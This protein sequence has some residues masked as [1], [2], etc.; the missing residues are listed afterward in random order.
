MQ[1]YEQ[2]HGIRL[3]DYLDLHA[4]LAPNAA[5]LID[6]TREFW[7][8][9][10]VVSGDYWIVDSENHGAP[11]A[12]RLIPRLRE[13]V[14]QYYP[15]TRIAITE[16]NWGSL[17]TLDGGLA[18]AEILGIFGR[19]GLD[20][21]TLW[22][23]PK[24]TDPAAFAFKIY[25]NYDGIGGAFGE[26]G[27]SAASDDANQLSVFAAQRS[28]QALTILVINK[29]A[30]DLTSAVS[31]ANFTA[32]SSAQVWRYSAANLGAIV[33]DTDA[34]AGGTGITN[35]FLANSITMLVVPAADN[36]PKPAITAVVNAASY[37]PQ[38]A[39]GTIVAV[40]G[41][42]LGPDTLTYGT[43]GANLLFG[44]DAAG[45]RVLFDGIAAPVWWSRKD[46]V[47][48]I[49][50][51]YAAW[52]PTTHVQVEY[53]GRRSDALEVPVSATAP[54]IFANTIKG[55]LNAAAFNV[56]N[57][58]LTVNTPDNPAAAG[59]E[60]ALYATGEGETDIP[61]VDGRIATAIF[62][63]PRAAVS[64][65]IGG[66]PAT[67]IKYAGAAPYAVAGAI[68]INAIIPAGVG[69]GAVPVK[70]TIGNQTSA[71]GVTIAVR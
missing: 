70:I 48:A 10:Y 24:P 23:P 41:T 25:R 59:S 28:D 54:G 32:G 35:K 49:V 44:T 20:L 14:N 42:G 15:G 46:V 68:Q 30:A 1:L 5:A 65:L 39:P 51:Y 63:K 17:N 47:A 27:V 21:A 19:E 55:V 38:I 6:S 2:Q 13:T 67:E 26:T 50:P 18:Q 43:V 66:K 29:T 57:G 53:Q 16:Y 3:L 36:G 11:V 22:G 34:V 71:D 64:V 52:K 8:P 33:R 40:F 62:P 69:P 61:G 37:T 45:A 4:Y 58:K 31:L 60:I 9:T 12:P 56:V 7:D